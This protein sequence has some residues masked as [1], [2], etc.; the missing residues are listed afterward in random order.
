[1]S[2]SQATA[3]VVAV[4]QKMV[5]DLQKGSAKHLTTELSP[6][7]TSKKHH[8]KVNKDARHEHLH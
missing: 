6:M 3:E 8:K 5:A 2:M 4:P 7:E 1:M